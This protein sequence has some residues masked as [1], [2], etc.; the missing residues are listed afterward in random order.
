MAPVGGLCHP[1]TVN[2]RAEVC[3]IIGVVVGFVASF[4]LFQDVAL[5]G[6]VA[7][8]LLLVGLTFLGYAIPS[9]VGVVRRGSPK[10]RRDSRCSG[11]MM[12]AG[13]V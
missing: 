9:E 11:M 2:A 10:G 12:P 5:G 1:P 7:K 8:I 3:G 4:L 13:G 6:L